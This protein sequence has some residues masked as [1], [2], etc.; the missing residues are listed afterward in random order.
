MGI[1]RNK[2]KRSP[3]KGVQGIDNITYGDVTTVSGGTLGEI[4]E[5]DRAAAKRGAQILAQA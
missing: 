2:K 3:G 4:R 1:S 5:A